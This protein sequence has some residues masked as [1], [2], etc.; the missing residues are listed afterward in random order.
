MK[1]YA[2]LLIL[3]LCPVLAA[4]PTT[5]PASLRTRIEGARSPALHW[6]DWHEHRTEV[7]AFYRL[8]DGHLAWSQGGIPTGQARALAARLAAADLKGLRASD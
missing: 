1:T 3:A 7:L 5:L 6:P 2:A 8:L 4:A